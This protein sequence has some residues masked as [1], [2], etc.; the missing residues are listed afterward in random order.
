MIDF[1]QEKNL[2]K[3]TLTKAAKEEFRSS[4]NFQTFGLFVVYTPLINPTQQFD[5]FG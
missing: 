1:D 4:R 3:K 2:Q 5:F